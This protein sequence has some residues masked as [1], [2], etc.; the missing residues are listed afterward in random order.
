[1]SE[2]H[3]AVLVRQLGEVLDGLAGVDW[4]L[5]DPGSAAEVLVALM[6]AG[7]RLDA[8]SEPPQVSCRVNGQLVLNAG[9]Q[10][11]CAVV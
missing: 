6:G 1:M 5:V 7:S 4:G 2:D 11:N 3:P 8:V 10:Q 9:G